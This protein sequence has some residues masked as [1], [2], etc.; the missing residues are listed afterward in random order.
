MSDAIDLPLD[1]DDRLYDPPL[2]DGLFFDERRRALVVTFVPSDEVSDS[3][4]EVAVIGEGTPE[5]DRVMA[6]LN[7]VSA[8]LTPTDRVVRVVHA[9]GG[10]YALHT[11]SGA[12]VELADDAPNPSTLEASDRLKQIADAAEMA[13]RVGHPA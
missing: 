5:F 1:D 7:Q 6:F 11:T 2:V 9:G 3:P 8:L 10:N 13:F 4:T 12:V